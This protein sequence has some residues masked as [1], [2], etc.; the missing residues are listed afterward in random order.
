MFD[1]T[2]VVQVG[3]EFLALRVS[4]VELGTCEAKVTRAGLFGDVGVQ[5][6][7]GDPSGEASPGISPSSGKRRRCNSGSSHLDEI[8]MNLTVLLCSCS[9]S[10]FLAHG[11]RA[12]VISLTAAADLSGLASYAI[13]LSGA[14]SHASSV[15]LR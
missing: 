6:S 8:S 12:K 11:E 13:H 2:S 1:P 9:G 14:T 4:S 5:W 10:L 15:K 3:F 7:A